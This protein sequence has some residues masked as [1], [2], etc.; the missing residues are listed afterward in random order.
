MSKSLE[1]RRLYGAIALVAVFFAFFTPLASADRAFASTGT[2]TI[3]ATGG[4]I[5]PPGGVTPA[6]SYDAASGVLSVNAASSIN[7]SYINARL[8]D[9]ALIVTASDIAVT[10]VIESTS[11]HRL[12]L[13]ST[14]DIV[15]ASEASVTTGGGD[16]ILWADSDGT[17]D[18]DTTGGEIALL[19]DAAIDTGAGGGNVVMGGGAAD[20]ADPG[21]PGGFVY[22]AYP[23]GIQPR[24][25]GGTGGS[26]AVFLNEASVEAGTGSVTIWGNGT[27]S[28]SSPFHMGVWIQLSTITAQGI[29]ISGVGSVLSQGA[30]QFGTFFGGSTLSSN[31]SI[32]VSGVGGEASVV[33]NDINQVGI[34]IVEQPYSGVDRTQSLIEATEDGTISLNGTGGARNTNVNNP[35]IYIEASSQVT[36]DRGDI[37][38]EGTS[39]FGGAAAAV[40]MGITPHSEEGDIFVTGNLS[41]AGT[42]AGGSIVLAGLSAPQGR[43]TITSPGSVTQTSAIIAT[44]MLLEG[45]GSFDLM[46]LS[47]NVAAIAGGDSA[48]KLG[49]LAY[50]DA[51]GGLTVG[52]VG[53]VQGIMATGPIL[54]V[55]Q[56]GDLTLDRPVVSEFEGSEAIVLVASVPSLVDEAG[57]GDIIVSGTGAVSIGQS[58]SALLFSGSQATSTGLSALTASAN[59]RFQVDDSTSP[60]AVSPAIGAAGT[61]VLYRVIGVV[62]ETSSTP[63][64]EG[65]ARSSSADSS[66][67]AVTQ[68]QLAATGGSNVPGLL[69]SALA[70]M[71]LGALGLLIRRRM[72]AS[73]YQS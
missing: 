35:G 42:E 13:K 57:D 58:S 44:E 34:V 48:E 60:D 40:V 36:S 72:L 23:T 59:I 26:A 38:L 12:T 49:S 16:V 47:N 2:L 29:E 20:V 69:L 46:N 9:K 71:L 50:S 37:S 17:G 11:S 73:E 67:A 28:T 10:G 31:G 52:D 3:T 4:D 62:S 6:W 63:S 66:V 24:T 51:D 5:T 8:N 18:A 41:V 32:E 64:R 55:T 53:T 30:S 54:I 56:S 68:P 1:L 22:G 61:F 39:A 65:S 43:V 19:K 70:M 25:T 27:G 15:F 45:T 14:T 7:A 21:I 33:G